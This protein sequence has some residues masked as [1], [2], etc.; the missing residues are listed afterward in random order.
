MPILSEIREVFSELIPFKRSVQAVTRKAPGEPC[1]RD[2]QIPFSSVSNGLF[3][4]TPVNTI[5]VPEEDCDDYSLDRLGFP[6]I[7]YDDKRLCDEFDEAE[8]NDFFDL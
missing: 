6:V 3:V 1:R 5:A 4:A 8:Y 2:S 7:I